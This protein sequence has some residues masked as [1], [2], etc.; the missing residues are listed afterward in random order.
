MKVTMM[1]TRMTIALRR[2]VMIRVTM[3][4]TMTLM[5]MMMVLR[6]VVDLHWKVLPGTR[7]DSRPPP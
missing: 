6:N 5:M 7:A 1:M 3:K 4:I 2:V